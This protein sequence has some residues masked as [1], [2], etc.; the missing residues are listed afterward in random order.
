MHPNL[1]HVDLDRLTGAL[2]V[3]I[4]LSFFVE[5]ALETGSHL[6]FF[7]LQDTQEEQIEL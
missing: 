2:P 7:Q 6:T 3:V 5:P 1:F 4:V